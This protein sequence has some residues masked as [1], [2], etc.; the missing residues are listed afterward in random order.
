VCVPSP[1]P[2][3]VYVTW[4]L[5]LSASTAESVQGLEPTEPGPS[6]VTPTVPV[7]EDF[8]PSASTSSTVAVQVVCSET[9]TAAGVQLSVVWVSRPSTVRTNAPS[10][11]EC[12]LS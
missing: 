4:Q 2:L 5:A 8:V 9:R 6:E 12:P 7:G 1:S 10:A 11:P 3:G